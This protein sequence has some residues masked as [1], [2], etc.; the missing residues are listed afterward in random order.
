VEN[1]V[2]LKMIAALAFVPPGEII[3][4]WNNLLLILQVWMQP[5]QQNVKDDLD[6]LFTYFEVNY[7]GQVRAGVRRDPRVAP[8]QLWNVHQRTIDHYG[9]TD[10]EVEGFHLKVVHT[11]GVQHP[12]LW[13]FLK[14]LQGLQAETEKS[15]AELNAGVI[16]RKQRPE[17]IRSAERVRNVVL[18]WANRQNLETYLRGISYNINFIRIRERLTCSQCNPSL[19]EKQT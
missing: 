7:I 8:I 14:G 1:A 19:P 13:K 6:D 15:I 9:R 2:H 11:V 3:Q 16:V 10:N 4:S 5:F 12:N 18:N 17:Y